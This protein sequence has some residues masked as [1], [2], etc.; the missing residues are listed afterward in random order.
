VDSS[1]VMVSRGQCGDLRQVVG[2][3]PS[4]A[5]VVAPSRLPTR[6]R[7]QPYARDSLCV[8]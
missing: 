8:E 3:D 5:Q 6:V 7:S 2:V 1:L 4:S